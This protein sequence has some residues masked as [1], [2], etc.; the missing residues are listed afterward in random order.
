[1]GFDTLAFE[2]QPACVALVGAALDKQVGPP[3]REP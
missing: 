1:M 3:A 2:P